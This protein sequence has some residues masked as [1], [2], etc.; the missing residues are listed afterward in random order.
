MT[1]DEIKRI[2]AASIPGDRPN[3]TDIAGDLVKLAILAVGRTDGVDF[4]RSRVTTNLVAGQARYLIGTDIFGGLGDV[5][6][7]NNIFLT[8][9]QSHEIMV[10]AEDDFWK[11]TTGVTGTGR[12]DLA[13]LYFKGNKPYLEVSRTPDSAYEIECTIK[14]KIDSLDKIPDNYHD[15]VVLNAI[16]LAGALGSAKMAKALA[17]IGLRDLV[18]DGL[19]KWNGTVIPLA[20]HLYQ[21]GS[22]GR[23]DSNNL[24]GY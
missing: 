7:V 8:A 3:A 24:R 9:Y 1:L 21:G 10:V 2:V 19:N 5:I 18:E 22:T 11:M 16:K 17:D 23:V 13:A 20:R 15:V 12:P 4:N 14:L 6:G